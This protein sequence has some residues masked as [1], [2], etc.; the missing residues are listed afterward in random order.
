MSFLD[1][2]KK[3]EDPTKAYIDYFDKEMTIMGILSTFCVAAASLVIDRLSGA[4]GGA[5][6]ARLA[7]LH[8]VQ[9][10]L[11]A[12][13]L[14]IAGLC[15]YLQRSKLGHFYGSICMSVAMPT[16][17]PWNT[18]RWL[19]EAYSW[20]TWLRYRIAFIVLAIAFIVFVFAI[21][22]TMY[23]TRLYL[24]GYG[25]WCYELLLVGLI[26]LSFGGHTMVYMT[27]RYSNN[28]YRHFKR[29]SLRTFPTAWKERKTPNHVG[30]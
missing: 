22:E 4:T 18:Q 12:S 25:L 24:W 11:G 19:T 17:H 3:I 6:F 8:P 7:T 14:L 13:L 20:G 21:G 16:L 5:F 10:Y 28:P 27:Y 1:G 30:D 23:P 15:F 26:V 2:S 29:L 9:I